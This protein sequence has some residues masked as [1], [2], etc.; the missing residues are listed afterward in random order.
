MPYCPECGEEVGPEA[1]FCPNCGAD[2]SAAAQTSTFR[3]SERRPREPYLLRFVSTGAV[4]I[5]IA[6]TYILYPID[7]AVIISYFESMANQEAFIKPPLILFDPAIFFFSAV[8][9]WSIIFSGLRVLFQRILRK[10][11][12]DLIGGFF[13]FFCAFLLINYAAD[14]FTGRTTL[15]YFITAIGLLVTVNAMLHYA[16][17]EK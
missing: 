9:V 3:I 7:F 8:G 10:A 5:I 4:L 16:F 2:L 1:K 13:C 11:L 15:A 6:L 14:V 12:G 17:P